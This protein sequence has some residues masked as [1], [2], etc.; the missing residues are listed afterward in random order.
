MTKDV[1]P[2]MDYTDEEDMEEGEDEEDEEV[3]RILAADV[4]DELEDI[5]PKRDI[6]TSMYLNFTKSIC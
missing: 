2:N 4:E 5:P 1:L 6:N 3:V